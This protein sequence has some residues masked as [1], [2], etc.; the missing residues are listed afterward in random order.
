MSAV[1]VPIYNSKLEVIKNLTGYRNAEL[2]RVDSYAYIN[3]YTNQTTNIDSNRSLEYAK[4]GYLPVDEYN[5]RKDEGTLPG[6]STDTGLSKGA[7]DQ[8][9]KRQ[10]RYKTGLLNSTGSDNTL[11]GR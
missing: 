2:T 7:Q 3:P 8:I 5:Q 9:A 1:A 10:Q 11:L 6:N 4:A